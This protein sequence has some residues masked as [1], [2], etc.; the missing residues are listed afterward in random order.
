MLSLVAIGILGY[1]VYLETSNKN[2]KIKPVTNS[3]SI[4]LDPYKPYMFQT[5]KDIIYSPQLIKKECNDGIYGI[6]QENIFMN[7]NEPI[8]LV[9]RHDNLIK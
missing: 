8:T 2:K 4:S 9:Y 5:I 1:S 7:G 6:T 3:P